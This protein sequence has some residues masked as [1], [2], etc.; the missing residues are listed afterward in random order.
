M[1]DSVGSRLLDEIVRVAGKRGWWIAYCEVVPSLAAGIQP[2]I[3]RMAASLDAAKAAVMSGDPVAAIRA[4]L[5][6]R[7][8]DDND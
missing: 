2:T 7:G 4:L 6:L 8:Y 5:A 3:M 1:G